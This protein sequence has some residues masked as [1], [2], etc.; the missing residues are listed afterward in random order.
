MPAVGSI[1]FNGMKISKEQKEKLF[2]I[3]YEEWSDEISEIEEFTRSLGKEL[4]H[5]IKNQ[6]VEMRER[7][8][9]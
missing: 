8:G 4:P 7:M 9:I 6:V 5:E 3:D 2:S 1:N